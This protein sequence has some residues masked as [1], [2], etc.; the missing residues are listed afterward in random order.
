MIRKLLNTLRRK[1]R[2]VYRS[3][4]T[5]KYVSYAFAMLNPRETVRE[6]A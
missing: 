1:P 2:Y 4:V 6:R 5:G 3:A